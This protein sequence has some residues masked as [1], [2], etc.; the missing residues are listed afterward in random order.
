VAQHLLF[1]YGTLQL[2]SVQLAIFGRTLDGEP[3]AVIGYVLTEV[4]IDDPAVV[5]ASGSAVHP[6]LVPSDDP[7]AAVEGTIYVLDDDHLLAADAYE[8]DAYERVAYP[9]RSGRTAWVYAL[10]QS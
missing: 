1:S 7:A 5:E 4:H 3:D 6:G 2:E 9:L 10:G 8:V